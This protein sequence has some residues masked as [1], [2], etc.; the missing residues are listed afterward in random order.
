[1]DI[2]LNAFNMTQNVFW[3]TIDGDWN[4]IWNKCI[5]KIQQQSIVP[6]FPPHTK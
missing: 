2:H 1:M 3:P 4:F 6:V 5:K